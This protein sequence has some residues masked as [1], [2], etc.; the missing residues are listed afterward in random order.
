MEVW[1]EKKAR[2]VVC[3]D[4]VDTQRGG[5]LSEV[6]PCRFGRMPRNAKGMDGVNN[7]RRL[8]IDLLYFSHFLNGHHLAMRRPAP[9]P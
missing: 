5:R 4:G 3:V 6:G 2:L 1:A 8:G 7:G 9:K